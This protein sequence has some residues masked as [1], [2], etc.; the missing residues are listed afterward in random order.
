MIPTG[1]YDALQLVQF[2]PL[3]LGG[4]RLMK[5]VWLVWIILGEHNWEMIRLTDCA[6]M[7]CR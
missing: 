7:C 6:Q 5:V 3:R 2:R 1:G 4:G